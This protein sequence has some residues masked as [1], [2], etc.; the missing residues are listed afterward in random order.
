MSKC[1]MELNGYCTGYTFEKCKGLEKCKFGKSK[2][3]QKAIEEAIV[4]HVITDGAFLYNPLKSRIDGAV[5]LPA[6]EYVGM[7][8]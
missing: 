3:Q 8:V 6:G 7:E 4:K 5:L 2:L 1:V